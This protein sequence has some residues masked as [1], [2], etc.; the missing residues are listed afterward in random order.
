MPEFYQG[1][2]PIQPPAIDLWLLSTESVAA[3]DLATLKACLGPPEQERLRHRR[4]AQ[5]QRQLIT[6]RGCL[7][8]L[9]SRYID[10]PPDSLSFSY[11]PRGKPA[12]DLTEALTDKGKHQ[13]LQFNL[14]HSGERLLVAV[15]GAA[16]VGAIGVD[17]EVLRPITQLPGLCRRYLTPAEADAVLAL[18]SAKTDHQFLRYWTGKEACLKALGLGIADSLQSL[19]LALTYLELTSELTP[20]GVTV[21]GDLEHPGQLYQWQPELGYVGAIAVQLAPQIT[22]AFRFYQTTPARLISDQRERHPGVK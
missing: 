7:R 11:G 17:L 9:L 6:S 15:S 14:S 21:Q 10:Q 2:P 22:P 16:G 12:L 18:P 1:P 19:E 5:A 8:H 20:V 4:L 13:A 3:A